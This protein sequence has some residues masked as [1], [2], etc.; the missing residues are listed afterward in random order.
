MKR[1]VRKE[2]RGNGMGW[3]ISTPHHFLSKFMPLWRDV[4]CIH[5]ESFFSITPCDILDTYLCKTNE[6]ASLCIGHTQ[7]NNN[8]ENKALDLRILNFPN[9]YPIDT[10]IT[11]IVSVL[12]QSVCAQKA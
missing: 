4:F 12:V 10:L 6:C 2:R 5:I 3:G 8:S 9:V 7:Y 11:N 1:A